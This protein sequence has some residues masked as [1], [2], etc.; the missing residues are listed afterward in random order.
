M[1]RLNEAGLIHKWSRTNI[2]NMRKCQGLRKG[3]Q[4]AVGPADIKPILNILIIGIG[5]ALVT[6][7]IEVVVNGLLKR[8]NIRSF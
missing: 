7:L 5:T 3:S 6:L 1:L 2:H 4:Q 8:R